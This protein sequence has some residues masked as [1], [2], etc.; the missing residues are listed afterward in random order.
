MN[1]GGIWWWGGVLGRAVMGSRF[2]GGAWN[3]HRPSEVDSLGRTLLFRVDGAS[4]GARPPGHPKK[5]DRLPGDPDC[6][7][8]GRP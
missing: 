3:F 8:R 1:A 4:F 6:A 2:A 7:P 5:Q